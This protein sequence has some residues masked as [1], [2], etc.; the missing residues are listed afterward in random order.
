MSRS[1]LWVGAGDLAQRSL[2]Y[3]PL[4]EWHTT[5][6]RRSQA[7]SA[8]QQHI[9]ADITE[10]NS[11]QQLPEASHIVYSPTPAGRSGAN[12]AAIYELGLSNLLKNINLATLERFLFISST[13]VYGADP[14]PQ[15]E[16]S[17]LKPP[18]F[19]G[20]A[21]VQ[22]E[23][24]LRHKLGDKLVVIRFS[25]L[26][27]PNRSGRVF[28]QLRQNNLSINPSLDNYANRIHIE[29]AARVCAHILQLDTVEDCYIGTDSTPLPLRHL[30]AYIAELLHCQGP[31]FDAKLAY[32]SKHFSNQRL[33]NSGFSFLYPDPLKGYRSFLAQNE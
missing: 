32:S 9:C 23:Q 29:D 7:T 8:F 13:A 19:N 26:Y 11:L 20:E 14:V 16:H 4:T 10:K 24:L 2:A 5:A 33:L 30:Y 17:L 1:L 12:Y 28:D 18:A 21:L 15:D 25:G 6:L 3:L 31:T 27:G 22:A